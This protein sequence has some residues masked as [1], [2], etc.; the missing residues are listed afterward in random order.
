MDRIFGFS[1]CLYYGSGGQYMAKLMG[2]FFA[3]NHQST[4]SFIS[5]TLVD[6]NTSH[7]TWF[8]SDISIIYGNNC[9]RKSSVGDCSVQR[10]SSVH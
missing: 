4:V 10:I 3:S 5:A 7:S 9:K 8:I 1:F 6:S 2:K